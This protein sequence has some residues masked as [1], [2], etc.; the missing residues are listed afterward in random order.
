ML[1]VKSGLR[2]ITGSPA[3][4]VI[5]M[6]KPRPLGNGEVFYKPLADKYG[7]LYFNSAKEAKEAIKRGVF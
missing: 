5:D 6:T 7:C 4:W 1:R 2:P 3:Y